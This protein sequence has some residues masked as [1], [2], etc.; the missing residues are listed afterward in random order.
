MINEN[1][2]LK[3]AALAQ[4]KLSEDEKKKFTSNLNSILGYVENLNA[5]NVQNVEPMSHVHGSSNIFREDRVIDGGDPE[6]IFKIV[7][8]RSGRFIKV[9]IIIS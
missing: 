9:P 8:D 7:P 5:R 3:I 6:T 1:D 2:V 4:L